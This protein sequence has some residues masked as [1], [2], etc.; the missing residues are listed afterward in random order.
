MSAPEYKPRPEPTLEDVKA[1]ARFV[2]DRAYALGSRA[3]VDT[4][5]YRAAQALAD[6][7]SLL[8]GYAESDASHGDSVTMQYFTLTVA[9]ERWTDHPDFNP[10]W[11]R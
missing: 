3:R 7:T 10:A 11:K 8:T 4:D 6:L 1:L 5:E 2:R 9:A